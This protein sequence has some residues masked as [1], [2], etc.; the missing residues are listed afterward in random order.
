MK[1]MVIYYSKFGNTQKVAEVVAA[2]LQSLGTARVVRAEELR[3]DELGE[4]DLVVAGS[5]T[6][7]MNLPEPMRLILKSLP[8]HSLR[9]KRV[10]AFDTSYRMSSW[11]TRFT[12][13]HRLAS[14]LRHL[15]GRMIAKPETFC[16]DAREGPLSE[17]EIERAAK[18]AEEMARVVR[19]DGGLSHQ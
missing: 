14:R 17:H 8:R 1:A 18:W 2:G 19:E 7:K 6:H 5:P 11:L 3:P 4:Q 12:A 16:V 9:G 10:A 13:S 15:G